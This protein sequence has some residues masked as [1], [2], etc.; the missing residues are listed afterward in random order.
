VLVNW[1]LSPLLWNM[2]VDGLLCRLHNAQSQAQG[3]ADDVVLL[4]KGKFVSTLCDRMQSALNCLDWCKEIGLYVN[5]EKTT[6]VLFMNNRKIGGF[7]N[8][9]LFGTVLRMTDKV[10]YSSS[11]Q[12]FEQDREE[13]PPRRKNSKNK[14]NF[15][16]ERT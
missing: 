8:P 11:L 9:R 16:W 4:E 15:F 10:K 6:M 14:S 3:Y 2:V 12:S 5:A 13:Q 1:G 7:Y